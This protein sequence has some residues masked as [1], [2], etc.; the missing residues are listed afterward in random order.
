MTPKPFV[1]FRMTLREEIAKNK[2]ELESITLSLFQLQEREEA[3]STSG[4]QPGT[5]KSRK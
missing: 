1:N 2:K 5:M 4:L 3:R